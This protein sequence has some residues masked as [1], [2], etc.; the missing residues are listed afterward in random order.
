MPVYIVECP[1]CR[2]SYKSFVLA[3]SRQPEIWECSKCGSRKAAPKPDVP[4]EQHPW[5]MKHRI[6]CAC[7][8][9]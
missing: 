8:G 3:G 6:G 1:D 7:C 5:E 2:H 9:M 4:E